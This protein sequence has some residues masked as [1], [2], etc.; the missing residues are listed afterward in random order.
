MNF[1]KSFAV[2][3]FIL[4]IA[5]HSSEIPPGNPISDRLYLVARELYGRGLLQKYEYG[6]EGG[7]LDDSVSAAK[8]L[9][10][11]YN[12]L[13]RDFADAES[14]PG[15]SASL[16]LL[17]SLRHADKTVNYVKLFPQLSINFDKRLAAKVFYR[18]DGELSDDPRYDGKSWN[19]SSGLV[20][21][22]SLE[23]LGD[24]FGIRF[25]VERFSWG[26]GRYANLMLSRQAMPMTMFGLS[27]R[28]SIFQF[29]SVAGF[30]SP[31]KDQLDQM[32]NDTSFFTSQ[33]RYLSAHS[34]SIRPHGN[35]SLSL[36]ELVL[37]GGPGR[38]LEPAYLFPLIWYHGEQL[39]SRMDDNS[40]F[41]IAADYR[42]AGKLWLYGELLVDD[43]Q[44]DNDTR[45]DYEP[46]QLAYLAGI[47]LYDLLVAGTSGGI[48]YGR[49]NNWT[50]NQARA[51]NRH[52]NSNFPIGY[53]DGPDNDHL[54]WFLSSWVTGDILL[55]Y[56]GSYRRLGE[57][58]IDSPWSRP[59][60]DS[61]QYF[62][63][64]PSGTVER[65]LLTSLEALI[66]VKNWIWG[67]LRFD[68][69]DIS[70]VENIPSQDDKGWEI[71]LDIGMK[72]PPFNREL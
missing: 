65:R 31:L 1:I 15:I 52:I 47:E 38:R 49:V 32:E 36:R 45:G 18:V 23:Y 25:G 12:L 48:E 17:N 60:L 50:F 33:Q 44:V 58:R 46:D 13:S 4:A 6:I 29:E 57:G 72:L 51:H 66:L 9:I 34:L 37:Y 28:K 2:L 22:A 40:M 59:W 10:R 8:S 11:K 24:S 63:P 19:G 41:A 35:L 67:N 70:N 16:W 55:S 5:A 26:M 68:F 69:T 53:P 56:N 42:K 27:Y 20:E 54:N 43:I 39:N 3:F 21:N 30:L 14:A 64:F 61:D 62:E 7:Y 71:R